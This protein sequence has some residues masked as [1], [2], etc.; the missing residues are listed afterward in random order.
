MEEKNV[1][2]DQLPSS[3]ARGGIMRVLKACGHS[4]LINML[5]MVARSLKPFQ[6]NWTTPKAV[7]NTGFLA[8]C[9]T[10]MC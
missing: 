7:L 5:N 6:D 8:Y 9:L 2:P 3:E 1:D 4:L 10:L